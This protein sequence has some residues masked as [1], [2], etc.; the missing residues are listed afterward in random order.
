MSE[1]FYQTL[2]AGNTTLSNLILNNY[3]KIGL[4]DE[5]MML[6]LHLLS[7]QNAGKSFPTIPELEER[8][9]ANATRIMG[10][11][12]RLI[13]EEYFSI[14]EQEDMKTGMRS[15]WYS[16]D[17]L[18]RKIGQLLEEQM[19]EKKNPIMDGN[20]QKNLMTMFEE[21]FG[22]PLSPIECE[23]IIMWVEQD[24][25]SES[26]IIS[27]L[28]EAVISGKLFFRYIDRILYEW[29][30]NQIRTPEQAREYSLKFRKHQRDER[31]SSVYQSKQTQKES[32]DLPEKFPFYNWLEGDK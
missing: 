11:L 24:G 25:Y 22:R 32:G 19:K 21:E 14:E 29:N 12:Q 4:T 23:N 28:R 5:E 3:G 16:F 6:I 10:M 27:A 13:R 7:F 26:L 15:E 2:E 8:M 9:S 17:L 20:G 31:S 1:W 18:Y 30:R